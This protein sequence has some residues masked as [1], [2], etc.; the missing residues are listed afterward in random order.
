MINYV[1]KT[2][3]LNYASLES[4]VAGTDRFNFIK[5]PVLDDQ[6]DDTPIV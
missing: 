5:K 4:Y 6:E 3:N 2:K 1:L